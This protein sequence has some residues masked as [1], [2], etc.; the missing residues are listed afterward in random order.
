MNAPIQYVAEPQHVRE[1][2]LVGSTD[3]DF[4]K[5]R[6]GDEELV[7][8]EQ[9]GKSQLLIIAADMKFMGV[10]FQEISFSIL[11]HH[12]DS[13]HWQRAAYLVQ[14]FNSRRLFAFS[15][16]IL[17][18][19]PY[20]FGK[21]NVS[22]TAPISMQLTLGGV[23]IF[24]AQMGNDERTANRAPSRCGQD[25]WEGPVFLPCQNRSVADG[26][27]FFGRIRGYTQTY[28]FLNS[29]D[30]ITIRP[31]PSAE[32]FQRLVDS[33]FVAEEWSVRPDATHAKSKTY[34]RRVALPASIKA[35]S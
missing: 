29:S 24:R 25:A 12:K 34:T 35:D 32:I 7:P 13:A 2:S 3:L 21:V 31:S 30:I 8:V 6:L 20:Y 17:F 4:W 28:P 14:A 10:R 16:R 23:T 5:T 33:H 1:V 11:V 15:E 19:T 22:V 9:N 27:L 18:R 26:R